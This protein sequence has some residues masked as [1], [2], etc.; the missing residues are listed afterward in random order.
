MG[1]FLLLLLTPYKFNKKWSLSAPSGGFGWLVL[2]WKRDINKAGISLRYKNDIYKFLRSILNF[3]V[4]WHGFNFN[5]VYNKM[6]KFQDPNERRKEMSYY[7]YEEFKKFIS[8]EDDLRWKCVFE[9][10]YYCG[11]RKGWIKK[12]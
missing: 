10:F 8:Y 12:V 3:G 5:N 6:T 11:L 7:N 2:L 4:K 1:S 9:I